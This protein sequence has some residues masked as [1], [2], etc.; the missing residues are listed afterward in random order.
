MQLT[1][2]ER[3][4]ALAIR[5]RIQSS[6]EL[7]NVSDLMCAQLAIVV[8][9]DVDEAIRRV[10]VMQE[11]KED[12]KIQDS[13]EEARRT[14]TKI[15]EYWPGA[16]LSAYFND[17]DEALVVVFDTPRFHGYKTQEKMKTTLLMAHYL[18][19][20][21]NPDIEATRKGVIFF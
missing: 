1:E 9:H 18:C 8:Q 7:D 4:W 6:A 10:W 16:I 14:F 19:R 2:Q 17:E 20:M 11:L 3:E 21:L 5:E 12:L 15:M 13:L